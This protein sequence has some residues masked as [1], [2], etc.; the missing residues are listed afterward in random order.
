[1]V[2]TSG[3][4]IMGGICFL[5]FLLIGLMSTTNEKK[6]LK[7]DIPI[8]L[9]LRKLSSRKLIIIC[10]LFSSLGSIFSIMVITF[11][12][13]F[14]LIWK[15]NN[16]LVIFVVM[17]NIV[18]GI[19]SNY[20]IKK[21]FHRKRPRGKK[22]VLAYHTSYPSGHTMGTLICYATLGILFYD[23]VINKSVQIV[24]LI[25]ISTV[26]LIISVSRVILRVHYP[27]DVIGGLALGITII[28][29]T[30]YIFI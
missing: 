18:F 14:Y 17:N 4:I 22:Y 16:Q 8:I 9:K 11:I 25:I 20:F 7:F 3:I 15:N 13:I 19:G 23:T 10:K 5:I 26:V 6:L 29:L 1:M 28:C 30:T 2:L 12:L 24:I 27:S 21:F